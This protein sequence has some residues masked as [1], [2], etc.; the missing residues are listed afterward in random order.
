[1]NAVHGAVAVAQQMHAGAPGGG[2]VAVVGDFQIF[3][4]PIVGIAEEQGV[5]NF[6]LAVDAGIGAVAVGGQN[7]SGVGFA[8]TFG[9]KLAG[10]V[11]A[12]FEENLIAGLKF[13]GIDG[14][15]GFP[16]V[17]GGEAGIGVVAG[18]GVNVILS[19][20]SREG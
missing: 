9:G 11:G 5:E 17:L 18:V 20:E 19:G 4:V 13:V 7:N 2:G 8:G 1:M 14:V 15:E 12:G 3:D 16:G 10:V 6:S